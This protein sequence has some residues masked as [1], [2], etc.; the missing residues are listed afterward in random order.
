MN[1]MFSGMINI[2]IY[3]YIFKLYNITSYAFIYLLVCL[4]ACLLVF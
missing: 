1:T 4:F 3:S 2:N